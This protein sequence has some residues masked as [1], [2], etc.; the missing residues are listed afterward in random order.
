M[1]FKIPNEI[2]DEI[3]GFIYLEKI[4][5]QK[6]KEYYCIF[7]N[8]SLINIQMYTVY[9]K[10]ISNLIQLY[11]LVSKYNKYNNDYEYPDKDWITGEVLNSDAN[12]HLYDALMTGCN[13]PFAIHSFV[14]YTDEIEQDIKLLVKLTPQSINFNLG[15][16]RCRYNVTPLYAACI[17]KK[18]P[19]SIVEFLLDSGANVNS[20]IELNGYQVKI[21]DD[22][23]K[24]IDSERYSSIHNLFVKYGLN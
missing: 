12:P 24:I 3:L 16:L 2:V 7:V 20:T 22:L 18:I 4:T 10:K 15:K 14:K 17:N 13:L 23:K 1:I 8:L 5:K 21:I 11:K 19:I 6:I 9:S